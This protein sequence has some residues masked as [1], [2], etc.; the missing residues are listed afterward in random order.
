MA[1]PATNDLDILIKPDAR[2]AAAVYRAPAK[3]GAPPEGLAP[4]PGCGRYVFPMPI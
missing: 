4:G 2:N 3:F 1:K